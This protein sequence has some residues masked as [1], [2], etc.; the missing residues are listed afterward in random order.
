MIQVE[1]MSSQFE[2]FSFLHYGFD[3]TSTDTGSGFLAAHNPAIACV[4]EC[5]PISPSDLSRTQP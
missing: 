5:F 1:L 4:C 2:I 3:Y